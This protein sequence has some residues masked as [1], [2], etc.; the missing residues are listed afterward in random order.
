MVWGQSVPVSAADHRHGRQTLVENGVNDRLN[1][2]GGADAHFI[3]DRHA[4]QSKRLL[5]ASQTDDTPNA[6]GDT[7]V[8]HVTHEQDCLKTADVDTLGQ[9]GVVEHHEFLRGILAPGVESIKEGLTIHLLPINDGTRLAGDIHAG[10]TTLCQLLTEIRFC[11]QFDNLLGRT[12]SNQNLAEGIVIN[13]IKQVLRITV[14]NHLLILNHV[15]LLD[16]N[17]RRK[18]VTFLNQL[19]S[20]NVAD[21]LTINLRIVHPR[22]GNSE[23]VLWRCRKKVAAS[24]SRREVLRSREKVTLDRIVRFIEVNA[25]DIDVCFHQTRKRM[26]GGKN[27]L[28]T[29]CLLTPITNNRRTSAAV[30]LGISTM[31][32]KYRNICVKLHKLSTELISQQQT[33]SDHYDN[34]GVTSVKIIKRV[35]DHTK[36]LS[37]A[38]R[39]YDLTFIMCQH[40]SQ[41]ILLVGAELH[42]FLIAY[43][44][45]IARW[46]LYR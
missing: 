36:G 6:L 18:N 2:L 23:R 21:H 41:C 32:V 30:I 45:I 17:L 7:D 43:G 46:G 13:S 11:Q 34:A 44:T 5:S 4:D 38:R 33:G 3:V 35:L 39:N 22:F 16:N 20:R 8:V 24:S 40:S 19:R 25:I 14:S 15:Q 10:V 31:C 27:Q 42:H 12:S 37:T 26:I 9:D 28:L 1:A 29:V